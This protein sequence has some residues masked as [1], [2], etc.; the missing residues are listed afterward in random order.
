MKLF[1]TQLPLCITSVDSNKVVFVNVFDFIK[2]EDGCVVIKSVHNS[3]NLEKIENSIKCG[4]MHTG[5][6]GTAHENTLKRYLNFSLQDN[7]ILV[8]FKSNGEHEL[9][10][11]GELKKL[12]E[13]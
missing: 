4:V 12:Q 3:E 5:D 1:N 2:K 11:Y 7:K 13:L 6:I 9:R 10:S 8:L